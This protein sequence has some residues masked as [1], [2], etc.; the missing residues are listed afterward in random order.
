[1]VIKLDSMM[2]FHLLV[3]CLL[4]FLP[5]FA[6][7]PTQTIR[8]TVTDQESGRPVPFTSIRLQQTT[9]GTVSDS[10]G[11]FALKHV[12]VG[13]YNLELSSTGYAALVLREIQVTSAKEVVLT[14]S[15]NEKV[16]EL[17]E[18]VV[19]PQ[20]NK[21]MP[22]NPMALASA[23]M[24]SVEEARRYAGGF[25]DPAR[26]VSGFAGVSTGGNVQSNAIIVRGNSPQS[27]Q[28][29][30]EGVEIPNPNHFADLSAF[31]GGGL[32]AMSAQ[33]LAN[34]DFYAGAMPAEYSNALSGVFDIFMRNGNNQ[35]AEHTFQLGII[36]IDA[37][38]E[39]PFKKGGKSSY[40]FNYRYSTLS[41]LKPIL[42]ENASGTK[43]QDLSFKLNFPTQHAGTFSLWG[44]GL[45]DGSGSQA[46][47]EATDR[48]YDE[49]R[50]SSDIKQYMG[51]AG[52][53][54][55]IF[56]NDKQ[57][58]KSTLA[59]TLNGINMTTD[60]LNTNLTA[61]PENK[62]DNQYTNYVL[63]SLLNT[64]FGAFHTNKTG[65]VLTN[66]N[67]NL[68]LKNANPS[69]SSLQLI[70]DE[71]GSSSLLS[72]Y[73][74]SKIN[75]GEKV[76]VNAGINAQLFT[77]D[78]RYTLEPRAGI[79]YRL[80]A[81]QSLA[82]AYGLHSRLERINYYFIRNSLG[83]PIN[84]DLGFTRAHHLVL[85]YDLVPTDKTH[86][87][88]E[89]YYQSLFDVPVMAD[90][91]FSLINQQNNWFFKGKL[92]NTGKGRNYGVDV[93]FERYLSQGYYYMATASLFQSRYAGGDN[94]WRNTRYNST[95]AIN[96]LAGKE[97]QVGVNNQNV[98]GLN[99]RLSYQGGQRYS[100]INLPLS[101]ARQEAQLDERQAFSQ[102]FSPAFVSHVTASYR[103][104]KK[105]TTREIALKII[106]ATMYKEFTGFRYNYLTRT[107]DEVREMTFIP[108][109]S[110]KIEF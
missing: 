41:L 30:L 82:L 59:A 31:G 5:G 2:R 15:L 54:H 65:I 67:Y 69:G 103:I 102:Q 23:R 35:K 39:G 17:T 98:L 89:A 66:M 37:A 43:Y 109:L 10:L 101:I 14:V 93:T 40:L 83:Q 49:D 97:W 24:V 87:K 70:T 12:P 77:L 78:N 18:V 57:Y 6:Q 75:L 96:L 79:S 88:I 100:P 16:A 34:S 48:K 91:S 95:F 26:L 9:L 7:Q 21:T 47:K 86:L 63:S 84:K 1:M 27:F 90:S 107:V 50:E 22:V 108:N 58:L 44:I 4:C 32:T 61:V 8:G 11:N 72:A 56:L 60:L 52:L 105:R 19:K 55:K 64:K 62:I 29:K 74:E 36:G 46:Q 71:K 3:L 94:V 13:R 25:D 68:L 81:N 20:T 51:S 110:Y 92:Q 33:L 106:N 99:V 53:S 104:N 42:P 80:S 85:G 28:W 73:S 45:L 76:T 38:S